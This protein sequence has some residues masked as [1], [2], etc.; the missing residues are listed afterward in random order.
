MELGVTSLGSTFLTS[1][2]G[3]LSGHAGTIK[4][5]GTLN[6]ECPDWS[7]ERSGKTETLSTDFVN[8]LHSDFKASV[9]F[10]CFYETIKPASFANALPEIL[11]EAGTAKEW[12]LPNINE[13]TYSLKEVKFEADALIQ[14]FV[15]FTKPQGAI[16]LTGYKLM[17]NGDANVLSINGK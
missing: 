6:L 9:S 16:S 15:S 3:E 5:S 13:G 17:Y 11:V 10:T 2:S 4:A 14:P 8:T 1:P 7:H 12:M